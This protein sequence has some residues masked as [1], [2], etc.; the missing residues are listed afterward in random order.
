MRNDAC[1][2]G[3]VNRNGGPA[4]QTIRGY[5]AGL[6]I[7]NLLNV[8]PHPNGVNLGVTFGETQEGND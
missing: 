4:H 1:D 5:M 8:T 2:K 6:P 7:P 3:G